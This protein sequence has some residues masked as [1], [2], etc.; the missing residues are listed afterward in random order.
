MPHDVACVER[1]LRDTARHRGDTDFL[2][3][4]EELGLTPGTSDLGVFKQAYRRHVA[5]RH[6]DR[7]AVGDADT[8]RLQR[9][10]RLQGGALA[11]EQRYG[12]LPVRP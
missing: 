2:V 9:L 4:Y 8:D 3:L 7:L 12:R 10:N 5:Q 6:P 11:F 1:S